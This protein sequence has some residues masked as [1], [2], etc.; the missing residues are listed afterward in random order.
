M[1]LKFL[2]SETG[3]NLSEIGAE[4]LNPLAISHGNPFSFAFCW[5][6]RAVKSIPRPMESKYLLANFSSMFFPHP[7]DAVASNT[8]CSKVFVQKCSSANSVFCYVSF[9]TYLKGKFNII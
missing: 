2:N 8:F 5:R 1:S 7:G 9:K 6:S 3:M 4:L